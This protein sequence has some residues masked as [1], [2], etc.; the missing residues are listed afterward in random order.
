MADFQIGAQV[1]LEASAEAE[2]TQ[3]SMKSPPGGI[4]VIDNARGG[5]PSEFAQN[6]MLQQMV[7]MMQ[8]Q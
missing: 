3:K 8:S 6:P 4:N 7:N 2:T 1:G 5:D